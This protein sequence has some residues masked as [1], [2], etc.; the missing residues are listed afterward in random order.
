MTM[1]SFPSIIENFVE[2]PKALFIFAHGAGADKSHNFMESFALKLNEKNIN[3]VRF[4]FPYMDKRLLDGKK[5]PPNRIPLLE[6]SYLLLL[7]KYIKNTS[8]PLFIGGKSMGGRVAATL[9]KQLLEHVKGTICIGYPF[10][11]QKKPENLRLAPLQETVLP[12]LIL[13]GDRDALGN[14]EEIENYALSDLCEVVY[15]VDGDHDLKPRVK[16]GYTHQ[17]HLKTA[18]EQLVRFIHEKS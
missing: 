6:D 5:Y 8:I 10:H 7:E 11:P 18:V 4:N 2:K 9:S 1:I 12:I 17:Q 16:S 15:F 14:K 3:V 13:Q